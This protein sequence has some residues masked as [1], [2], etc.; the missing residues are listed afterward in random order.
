MLGERGSRLST[1]QRQRLGI[2][3]AVIKD[4]PILVLDEPTA[5][6]DAETE[7]KV[8]RNLAE[9]GRDRA[10]FVVTHRLSTIRRADQI[11]YLREGEVVESGSHRDLVALDGGAYRRFVELEQAL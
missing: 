10:I 8:M 7:L 4:P 5:S 11:V 9:W 1:G 3:R 2:A 6:L